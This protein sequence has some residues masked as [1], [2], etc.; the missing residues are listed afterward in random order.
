MR[1][2][3][4]E[5]MKRVCTGVLAAAS[6][7][8]GAAR[9]DVLAEGQKGVRLSI[10]VQADVPPGKKLILAHTFRVLDVLQPDAPARVEWHPFGGAMQIMSVPAASIDAK[11]EEQRQNQ[12]RGALEKIVAAGQPCHE[13]FKGYRSVPL[14]ALADEI[15]WVYRVAFSGEICTATLLRMELYDKEGKAVDATGLRD[16]PAVP[17]G[18]HAA[19]ASDAAA[20]PATKGVCGCEVGPGAAA[21]SA[22]AGTWAA[23]LGLALAARRRRLG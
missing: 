23:L 5:G 1:I 6:L 20:P 22:W 19:P 4:R 21:G 8:A 2:V 12:E 18:T 17:I 11:V 7:L 13:P 3:V 14:E 9:A 10:Q 16:L 15:R